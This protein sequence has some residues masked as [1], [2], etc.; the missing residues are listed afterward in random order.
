M[1]RAIKYWNQ[2][3]SDEANFSTC[4]TKYEII[5]GLFPDNAGYAELCEIAAQYGMV[6]QGTVKTNRKSDGITVTHTILLTETKKININTFGNETENRPVYLGF[7]SL[8]K[9]SIFSALETLDN[10]P[11]QSKEYDSALHELV[12]SGRGYELGIEETGYHGQNRKNIIVMAG[13]HYYHVL[14]FLGYSLKKMESQ[15]KIEDRYFSD[16]VTACSGCSEYDDNDDCYKT[17]FR[18]IESFGELGLNCGCFTDYALNNIDDYA[19][20]SNKAIELEQVKTLQKCRRLKHIERF[21]SGWVDGR[22]GYYAG[23]YCREGEPES[24]LAELLK[25]NP[26]K[27]YVFTHDESGQF[28]SYFSVWELKPA[29]KSR[30]RR[31]KKPKVFQ[32]VIRGIQPDTGKT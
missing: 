30:A 22:G 1:K 5:S 31:S 16:S 17:N 13:W 8:P 29:R 6:E 27:Q 15:A 20:D 14:P 25:A 28:Q 3:E 4:S 9:S 7:V 12:N 2:Y 23:E 32:G 11:P 24:V 26:E 21:I 10:D 19:N 18:Y